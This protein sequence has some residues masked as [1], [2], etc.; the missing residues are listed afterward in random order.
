M[1]IDRRLPHDFERRQ[2]IGRAIEAENESALIAI[3]WNLIRLRDEGDE[4]RIEV[5]DRPSRWRNR[6]RSER[7]T[8]GDDL[9][10]C[11]VD[12]RLRMV[13]VL[14]DDIVTAIVE[15]FIRFDGVTRW[16]IFVATHEERIEANHFAIERRP[17]LDNENTRC[18]NRIEA[19]YETALSAAGWNEVVACCE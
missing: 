15:R 14:D 4:R 18:G 7:H 19:K 17:P 3:R 1:S 13:S 9:E 5:R 10:M 12:R 16:R 6:R 8:R 11:I 2:H